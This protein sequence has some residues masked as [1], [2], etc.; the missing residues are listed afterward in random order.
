LPVVAPSGTVTVRLVLVTLVIAVA[1]T[2]LNLTSGAGFKLT[3]LITTSVPG[4][5]PTG[6]KLLTAGK[7]VGVK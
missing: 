7:E 2:P 3:P 4:K 6:E 5:P 1:I